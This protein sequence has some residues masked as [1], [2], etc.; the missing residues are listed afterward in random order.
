MILGSC[1]QTYYSVPITN[2]SS[3]T[4]RFSYN[5]SIDDLVSQ[6]AKVYSVVAYTQPPAFL[7]VVP[8]GTR[9]VGMERDGDGYKFVDL[10]LIPLHIANTLPVPITIE[11]EDFIDD[12]SNK[13]VLSINSNTEKKTANIYTKTPVFT[14]TADGYSTQVTYTITD[15]TMYVVVR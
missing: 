11:A 15:N 9:S 2:N 12:G 6:K 7:G 5:G 14:V 10:P 13:T 3:K 4:V 8:E 1:E